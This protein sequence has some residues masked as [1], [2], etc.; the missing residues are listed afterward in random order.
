MK[1]SIFLHFLSWA[2]ALLFL[3]S[4][5]D[6]KELDHT[7]V[8]E[9]TNLFTPENNTS[10]KL[11]PASG[12][13]VF[14]WGQAKAEDNGI[15]F[16]EVVFDK[17]SGDFSDPI[18]SIKSDGNGIG[19]MLT[20]SYASL[21]QIAKMAGIASQS[22]GKIKWTVF[23]SK[24]INV[25]K[26]SVSHMLEL[27]RPAG[28]AEIPSALYIT[29]SASEGGETLS[30]A[31]PFKQ[32]QSGVF[33]IYTSLKAGTYNFASGNTGTPITYSINNGRMVEGGTTTVTGDTKVYR[34][35]LNLN[36]ASAEFT[37]IKSLGLWFSADNKIWYDLP[38][39]GKGTWEIKNA[40]VEFKQEGWGRD[41]RY[42]FRFT[43]LNAAGEES[44]EW[45]GSQNSDNSR[46]NSNT[47][48]S[49]WYMF[50]VNSSQYDYAFKFNENADRKTADIKVD[51]SA[52][53]D[54]YTHSVTVK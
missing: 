4:C 15:V 3:T 54:Q 31:L 8:T 29:G 10:I 25:K 19:N 1:N 44:M 38:Y 43:V 48:L 9:V 20:M 34:I 52:T 26:S 16:Y 13:A 45:Y 35:R 18:Y 27:E 7:Q 33:E 51:F 24:G 53:A 46:P 36:N 2:A 32:T 17:E 6:D 41:E 50:P 37:E 40:P 12:S 30:E 14:E 28:F 39:A 21:N 23:S 11:E 49:Y 5:E 22:K 42:K 47:A